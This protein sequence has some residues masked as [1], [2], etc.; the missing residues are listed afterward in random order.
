MCCGAGVKQAAQYVPP[1]AKKMTK[2]KS[3]QTKPGLDEIPQEELDEAV[4]ASGFGWQKNE[5][6]QQESE[7]LPGAYYGNPTEVPADKNAPANVSAREKDLDQR[8]ADINS[9]YH[10][11]AK[12][13][14]EREDAVAAREEALKAEQ[15]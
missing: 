13:L 9:D 5:L 7:P 10:T 11:K 1:K 14:K 6:D 12:E 4:E 8:E 3:I 15:K 2:S